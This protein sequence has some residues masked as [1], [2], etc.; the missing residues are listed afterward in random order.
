MIQLITQVSEECSTIFSW[1]NQSN[2]KWCH[3]GTF[4]TSCQPCYDL[5]FPMVQLI[6]PAMTS[7]AK[8]GG[9]SEQ[10]FCCCWLLSG[11]DPICML[12][13]CQPAYSHWRCAQSVG[14]KSLTTCWFSGE[15]PDAWPGSPVNT[16]S[17]HRSSQPRWA[18]EN[19]VLEKC[20]E[21]I[22]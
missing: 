12:Y 20:Y 19:V 3:N 17:R 15:E 6:D 13:V 8:N 4:F 9:C 21:Y 5:P 11:G 7:L 22:T 10:H 2:E 1:P 14:F 16:Y 18:G